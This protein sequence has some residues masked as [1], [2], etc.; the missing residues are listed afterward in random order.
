MNESSD[1]GPYRLIRGLSHVEIPPNG[2]LTLP[3]VWRSTLQGELVIVGMGD[4]VEIWP[5]AR[6]EASLNDK[7][8]LFLRL[9]NG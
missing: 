3:A 4:H 9:L 5:K 2:V 6:W 1:D 7:T 8:K